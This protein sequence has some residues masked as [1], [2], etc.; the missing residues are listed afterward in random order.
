MDTLLFR[1]ALVQHALCEPDAPIHDLVLRRDNTDGA[2]VII[3]DQIVSNR[4][5]GVGDDLY[6][7][8]NQGRQLGG[9][10]GLAV[11]LD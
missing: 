4:H 1:A 9:H 2:G 11:D 6:S 7:S 10:Y 3:T 5:T 8:S